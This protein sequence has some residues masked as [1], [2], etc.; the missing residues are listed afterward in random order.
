MNDLKPTAH[1]RWV[2]REVAAQQVHANPDVWSGHVTN[3][4]Q[5]WWAPDVPAYMVDPSQGEWRDVAV[6]SEGG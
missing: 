6:G 4:L 2:R 3:I 1:L 5:Q